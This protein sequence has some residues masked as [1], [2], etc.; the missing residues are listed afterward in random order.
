M[1]A[2][3]VEEVVVAAAAILEACRHHHILQRRPPRPAPCEREKREEA[4][5]ASNSNSPHNPGA[6]GDIPCHLCCQRMCRRPVGHTAKGSTVM[7]RTEARAVAANAVAHP[8][9]K[10]MTREE[11]AQ[12]AAMAKEATRGAS[13]AYGQTVL[14]KKVVA[15]CRLFNAMRQTESTTCRLGG[16]TEPSRAVW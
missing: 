13:V 11:A 16:V 12:P 9:A 10:A 2:V 7:H 8:T 5:I 15:S 6:E 3:E 1:E 4:R 14:V